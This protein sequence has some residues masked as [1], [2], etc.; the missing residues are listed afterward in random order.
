MAGKLWFLQ[1][2]HLFEQLRAQEIA[3]LEAR[4]LVRTLPRNTSIYLPTDQGQ[5]V[6]LVAEGRVKIFHLT[7]DGKQSI[8]AFV[9]TGELFGELALLDSGPRDEFAETIERSTI[10]LIPRDALDGLLQQ[11]PDLALGI[12]KLIGLRR[13]RIERRLKN[14][15]YLPSRDRLCFLLLELAEQYGVGR[16]DSRDGPAV[17]LS[18]RLSHQD[19]ANLIGSTR[20][21]ITVLLGE[22]QQEGLLAVGRKS[23]RIN[24]LPRLA[25]TVHAVP[26]PLPRGALPPGGD[27]RVAPRSQ[28]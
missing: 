24:D 12:T 2:C 22:L 3:Q 9:N 20:E 19:L 23:M 25:A 15:L 28:M 10:V 1:R 21:T 6:F 18:I 14:L 13:R 27:G 8:L 17:E 16:P 7:P 4:S 11:R 26:P 5:A